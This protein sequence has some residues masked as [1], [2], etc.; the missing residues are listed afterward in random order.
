MTHLQ[1][2]RPRSH[3]MDCETE[4]IQSW[5]G[6]VSDGNSM[7]DFDVV[8]T[9]AEFTGILVIASHLGELLGFT[10]CRVSSTGCPKK[11]SSQ[12]YTKLL[13]PFICH[14]FWY[15]HT[16][17]INPNVPVTISYSCRD[18]WKEG[19]CRD[20]RQETL[21]TCPGVQQSSDKKWKKKEISNEWPVPQPS[22]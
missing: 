12:Q 21:S 15:F 11:M 14:L 20:E 3:V 9:T 2:T 16:F 22:S 7:L 17:H 8:C 5:L 13:Q 4:A 1:Q 6:V 19:R 18:I 10:H